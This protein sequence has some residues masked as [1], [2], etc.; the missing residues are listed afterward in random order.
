MASIPA[1]VTSSRLLNFSEANRSDRA[2]LSLYNIFEL[3]IFHIKEWKFGYRIES[4]SLAAKIENSFT[5]RCTCYAPTWI[6]A[7]GIYSLVSS[8][9]TALF[10]HAI[11]YPCIK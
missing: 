11:V 4:R 10:D 2:D 6:Q 5:A 9:T 3:V 8:I 7:G 1:R